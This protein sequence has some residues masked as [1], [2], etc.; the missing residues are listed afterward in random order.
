MERLTDKG[1][2]HWVDTESNQNVDAGLAA[3]ETALLHVECHLYTHNKCSID[4]CQTR[5]RRH[6]CDGLPQGPSQQGTDRRPAG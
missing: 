3:L 2:Q 5:A 1:K 4:P 6:R